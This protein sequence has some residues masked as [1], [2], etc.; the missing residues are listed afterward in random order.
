MTNS[1]EK[2]SFKA[3]EIIMRQGEE[4]HA[5]YVIEKGRVE[6]LIQ[7]PDGVEQSVGTR[8]VGTMIGEMAIVDRAPRTAT[9]RAIEDCSLL[10]ITAE[11][12][13]RRLEETDPIL[14]MTAQV[15]LT[16]YRDTLTRAHISG[17][18]RSWPPVEAVEL[19]YAGQSHAVESIKIA[20]EFKDALDRKQLLLHY[21]PIMNLQTGVVAGFEALMRW[22]H[23]ERGPISP[24]VFIPIAEK[25]GLIVQASQWALR[26]ACAA[27]KRTEA[28]TG[29]DRHL[30]MSVNFSSSDFASD[31]FVNSVYNTIS[32]SD[33]R[34]DQVHL[35]ITERLLMDQPDNARETLM[36]CR[37]AGMSIAIDDF[38]TGYSSLSYLH[39]FPIDTLKIDQS[40]V[41][42]MRKNA[43][44]MALIRSIIALGKNMGMKIIAEGVEEAVEGDTLRELGCDMAQ[45]YYFARP[46]AEADLVKFVRDSL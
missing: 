25:S 12:F 35:E 6:I 38:G 44:S 13:S 36:M 10:E 30:F 28:R 31:D 17:E 11:D 4:G 37:K 19:N 9:V 32:E 8:G 2:K 34:P 21:Q 27:L 7:R 22:N 39:Y 24:G 23:P 43:N 46:M 45:G 16:R 3:G 29:Y 1:E 41:R 5:A 40:F 33:V 26:E 20:N 15:I 14:R 42:D 18:N